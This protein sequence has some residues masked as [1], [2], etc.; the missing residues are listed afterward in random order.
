MRI[1][2]WL[3]YQH[4]NGG[5]HYPWVKLYRSLLDDMEYFYLDVT[6]SKLLIYLF[7][8]ASEGDGELPTVE[9]MAFRLRVSEKFINTNLKKLSSW[10]EYEYPAI[11]CKGTQTGT[12]KG[13][14][15]IDIEIEGDVD[16]DKESDNTLSGVPAEVKPKPKQS[17]I[18][19]TTT[20][21]WVA[22]AQA[23]FL[24]AAFDAYPPVKW[25]GRVGD[26][27]IQAAWDRAAKREGGHEVLQDLVM[28]DLKRWD[29]KFAPKMAKYLDESWYS[30]NGTIDDGHLDDLDF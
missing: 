22:Q 20:R 6:A 1:R 30:K 5:K 7:L 4:K 23:T 9:K 12:Q 11:E 21:D 25:K 10:I 15:D 29:G 18:K 14:L 17:S 13:T 24:K 26:P 2:N 3:K 19:G 28:K 16:K 27:E 8:L